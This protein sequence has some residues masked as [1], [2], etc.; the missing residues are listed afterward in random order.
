MWAAMHDDSAPAISEFEGSGA[1]RPKV[2]AH[3]SSGYEPPCDVTPIIERMLDSVPPKYLVGL[4]EVVLADSCGLS[5]ERRRSATK[6]R[7]KKVRTSAARG[8]YYPAW[9]G[10]LP[11]IEIFIDNT[12]KP[13][14]K[15][16][17][18]KVPLFRES[19]IA[20]VLFHEI[21]HHIHYTVRPE[22]REKE[23]VA[24]VLKVRLERI[25][26]RQRSGIIGLI[27]QLL[28]L[29][30]SPVVHW[31]HLKSMKYQRKKGWI[32]KAEFEELTRKRL[33]G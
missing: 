16:F 11:W 9:K 22:Y 31:L 32:S 19:E 5:R 1:R 25:Y 28:R 27:F 15:G 29:F 30:A 20:G 18:P 23:D 7:R 14:G 21:G 10:R 3:Y 2:V 24:D 13:L 4:S 17:L 33:R 12:L 8:L 26:W 6:S